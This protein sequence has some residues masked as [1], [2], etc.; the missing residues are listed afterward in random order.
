MV[1]KNDIAK[2]KNLEDIIKNLRKFDTILVAR[3][4]GCTSVYGL[5]NKREVEIFRY[6]SIQNAKKNNQN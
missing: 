3:C 4:S 5:M 2:R 6:Y 1:R